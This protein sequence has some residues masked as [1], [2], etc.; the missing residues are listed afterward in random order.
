MAAREGRLELVQLAHRAWV[1]RQTAAA[2]LVEDKQLLLRMLAA[3][4]SSPTLVRRS[5]RGQGYLPNLASLKIGGPAGAAAQQA[6]QAG[7]VPIAADLLERGA[8]TV[9]TTVDWE[10]KV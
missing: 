9:A 2:G 4:S 10:I 6:L 5:R 1:K 3:V 8:I 7:Q